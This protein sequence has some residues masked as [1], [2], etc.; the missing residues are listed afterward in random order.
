MLA[1]WQLELYLQIAVVAVP[2]AVYFLVLGLLNSQKRPQM[3]SGRMDFSLLIASLAPLFAIPALDWLGTNLLT[4]SA[5][6][7]AVAATMAALSPRSYRSWVVYNISMNKALR[8]VGRALDLAGFRYSR[9]EDRF[10]LEG[11]PNIHLASFPILRNVSV[12]ISPTDKCRR[13]ALR[14][15]EAELART[16]GAVEVTASP[17]AVSFVLV[18]TAMIVAPLILLADHVPEMVRILTDLVK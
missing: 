6:V 12:H 5:C 14:R 3:L 13:A 16:I 10:Y 18:A 1:S 15:F 2:V 9:R 17:M 8:C 11:G 4:I 7:A